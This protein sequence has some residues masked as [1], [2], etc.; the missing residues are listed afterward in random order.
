VVNGAFTTRGRHHNFPRGVPWGCERNAGGGP[1]FSAVSSESGFTF[2]IRS[3]GRTMA[4]ITQ[5]ADLFNE[6]AFAYR[7]NERTCLTLITRVAQSRIE[8]PGCRL[9]VL[10]ISS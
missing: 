7:L 10:I 5:R 4:R 3:A 8:D 6:R 9:D 2:I 1:L